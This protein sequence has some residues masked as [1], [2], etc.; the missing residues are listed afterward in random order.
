MAFDDQEQ[1]T[2]TSSRELADMLSSMVLSPSPLSLDQQHSQSHHQGARRPF[3]RQSSGPLTEASSVEDASTEPDHE[4]HDNKHMLQAIPSFGSPLTP[5][6]RAAA[7]FGVSGGGSTSHSAMAPMAYGGSSSPRDMDSDDIPALPQRSHWARNSMSKPLAR[8]RASFQ[9][10]WTFTLS[11]Q[12]G[13]SLTVPMGNDNQQ[14]AASSLPHPPGTPDPRRRL[15]RNHT[16]P[17]RASSEP[18]SS[19][20]AFRFT[21]FSTPQQVAGT[22]RPCT[23]PPSRS[24]IRCHSFS[25]TSLSIVKSS[26]SDISHPRTQQGR[27]PRAP[28]KRTRRLLPASSLYFTQMNTVSLSSPSRLPSAH[29]C[30]QEHCRGGCASASSSRS[31]PLTKRPR[32]AGSES[33]IMTHPG[34]RRPPRHGSVPMSPPTPCPKND[35]LPGTS[36]FPPRGTFARSLSMTDPNDLGLR[37]VTQHPLDTHTSPS[38]S[39]AGTPMDVLFAMHPPPDP[40]S[41]CGKQAERV[42]A[43]RAVDML[44]QSM[45]HGLALR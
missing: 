29:D 11:G 28:G 4:D 12:P 2:P 24:P 13:D 36:A 15:A 25:P 39:H 33:E 37:P 30:S 10:T 35:P 34:R 40:M 42:Q 23:T 16:A 17:V 31:A 1:T 21:A 32:R 9:R 14:T 26:R 8:P 6:Q 43:A 45:E 27:L 20:A 19:S 3:R 22:K 38:F 41:P 7:L 5:G 18:S 44:A